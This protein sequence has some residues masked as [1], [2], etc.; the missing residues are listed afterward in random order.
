MSRF[1]ADKEEDEMKKFSGYLVQ[2]LHADAPWVECPV[3][4]NLHL[5]LVKGQ[6]CAACL[7]NSQLATLRLVA[8]LSPSVRNARGGTMVYRAKIGSA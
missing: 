2:D 3:C 4:G 6:T 1:P 8:A 7:Y 5:C